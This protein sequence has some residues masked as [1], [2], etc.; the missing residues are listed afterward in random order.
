MKHTLGL[1]ALRLEGRRLKVD[2]RRSKIY[3]PRQGD[4]KSSLPCKNVP[5]FFHNM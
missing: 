3:R 5:F 4:C 1:D 2:Q